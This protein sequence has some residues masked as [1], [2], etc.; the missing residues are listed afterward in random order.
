VGLSQ[1]MYGV[2]QTSP[3]KEQTQLRA[4]IQQRMGCSPASVGGLAD[5][6]TKSSIRPWGPGTYIESNRIEQAEHSIKAS[7][8]EQ[9]LVSQETIHWEVSCLLVYSLSNLSLARENIYYNPS[10]KL[11]F[12]CKESL[13]FDIYNVCQWLFNRTVWIFSY[14]YLIKESSHNVSSDHLKMYSQDPSP[15]YLT[16]YL[17]ETVF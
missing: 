9:L 17:I 3:K 8:R 2:L 16:E 1:R 5:R 4:N 12:K 15:Q 14:T 6:K 11:N 7:S 10:K 13:L